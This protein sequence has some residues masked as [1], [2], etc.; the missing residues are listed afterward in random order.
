MHVMFEKSL[1]MPCVWQGMPSPLPF[2]AGGKLVSRIRLL[3]RVH[4][5]VAV[6]D[7]NLRGEGEPRALTSPKTW[8]PPASVLNVKRRD[9]RLICIGL[10][11]S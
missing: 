3:P 11:D 7:T 4:M 6:L 8:V 5:H 9:P 1:H 10:H 2:N